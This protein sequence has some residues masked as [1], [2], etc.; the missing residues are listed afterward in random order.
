MVRVLS[1][2][3]EE[4]IRA[5]HRLGRLL[6]AGRTVL[7]HGE[8]GSGKT[9]FV[10]GV[11]RALGIRERD[12]ASASFTIVAEYDSDPPLYHID[13]YRLE[14]ES[15]LESAGVYEYIGGRGIAVVEWAEKAGAGCADGAVTVRINFLSA[16]ERE[17][18]IE[19][20]DEKDWFHLPERPARAGGNP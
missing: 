5:G 18:I 17:I 11:A 20:I 6:G 9:T 16:T 1:R 2:S 19:G 10:K 14:S 3:P 7:L 12:I 8:L 15:D 13:L 4:T